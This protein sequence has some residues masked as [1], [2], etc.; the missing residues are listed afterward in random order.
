[1]NT[2]ALNLAHIQLAD[3]HA[4]LMSLACAHAR[5]PEVITAE[6]VADAEAAVADAEVALQQARRVYEMAQ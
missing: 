2:D 4:D 5:M 3:A 1:M 6:D